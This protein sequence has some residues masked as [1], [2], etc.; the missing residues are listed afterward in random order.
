MREY[1]EKTISNCWDM[2]KKGGYFIVCLNNYHELNQDLLK[3][4]FKKG[5]RLSQ[6]L[7]S[8]GL[9]RGLMHGGE[10]KRTYSDPI[11]VFEKVDCPVSVE[12][13]LVK[14]DTAENSSTEKEDEIAIKRSPRVYIDFNLII[15]KFKEVAPMKGMSRD[16]YKDPSLLGVNTYKIEHHFGSWKAFIV[17]CG[18]KPQYED[19]SKEEIVKDYLEECL[20]NNE[21]LTFYKYGMSKI[22]FLEGEEG[23]KLGTR[24]TLR[25]K[26]LFNTGKPYHHL[27]D[28]LKSVALQPDLWPGFLEKIK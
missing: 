11:Y 21:A 23:R 27:L 25:L 2:L 9:S 17:K 4:C 14:K 22:G 5:F 16:T 15:E 10:V 19:H 26:R 12:D 24:Y 18:F 8:L 1:L 3:I 20:K 6:K 13:I 7:F 28:E